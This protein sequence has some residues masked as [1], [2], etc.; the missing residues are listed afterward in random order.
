LIILTA[1][2]TSTPAK[3]SGQVDLNTASVK[4]SQT[5]K[6]ANATVTKEP[7]IDETAPVGGVVILNPITTAATPLLYK[8]GDY[9][10]F[11]WNYTNLIATP[12]AVDLILS[13]SQVRQTW[14]LTGNMSFEEPGSFT[15]DSRVQQTDVKAPLLTEKY[16]LIIKNSEDE[17]TATPKPGHLFQGQLAFAMYT[18]KPYKPLE[19]WNC[20]TC[21]NAAVSDMDRKA[22]GFAMTMSAITV[23]SFTWFVAGFRL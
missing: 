7:E 16:T 17:I 13:C 23:L 9:V 10:T 18:P 19:E 11:G 6:N 4:P 20:A 8:A 22:L 14:T 2:P 1:A 12:T 21:A 15:W 5:G 3:K